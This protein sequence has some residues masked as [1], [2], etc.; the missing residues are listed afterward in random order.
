MLEQTCLKNRTHHKLKGNVKE[1]GSNKCKKKYK[2]KLR[3]K[4]KKT[5]KLNYHTQSIFSK[6]SHVSIFITGRDGR[7]HYVILK[8]K[9]TIWP[10]KEYIALRRIIMYL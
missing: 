1:T 4:K 10:N 3:Q 5:P 7:H 6:V 2:S 9:T 8:N